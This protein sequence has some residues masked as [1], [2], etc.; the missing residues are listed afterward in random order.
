MSKNQERLER[1]LQMPLREYLRKRYVEDELTIKQVAKELNCAVGTV[2]NW[3]S[4][5]NLNQNKPK[6][7]KG[8]N[9]GEMKEILELKREDHE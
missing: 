4:F 8:L 7:N 2:F 5:Y 3:I 6:W 1:Y 9:K